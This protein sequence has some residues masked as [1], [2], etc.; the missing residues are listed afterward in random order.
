MPLYRERARARRRAID[1]VG[2]RGRLD[3]RLRFAGATIEGCTIARVIA[4]KTLQSY[5]EASCDITRVNGRGDRSRSRWTLLTISIEVVV[6]RLAGQRRRARSASGVS[7]AASIAS[8]DVCR[9]HAL[10]PRRSSAS[11]RTLSCAS[12]P[13][14]RRS[15]LATRSSQFHQTTAHDTS[16]RRAALSFPRLPHVHTEACPHEAAM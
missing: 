2:Q 12:G 15:Q 14:T 6:T 10:A 8:K 7:T 11:R 13:S 9:M 16:P 1:S 5:F 3:T 4:P